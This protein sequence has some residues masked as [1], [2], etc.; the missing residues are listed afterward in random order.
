[1][2]VDNVFADPLTPAAMLER[3][4]P[5]VSLP[6]DRRLAYGYFDGRRSVLALVDLVTGDAKL[7]SSNDGIYHSAA[8]GRD[9]SAYFLLVDTVTREEIG[10]FRLRRDEQQPQ[11]LAKRKPEPSPTDGS[12]VYVTPRGDRVAILDCAAAQCWLRLYDANDGSPQGE[13]RTPHSTVLGVTDDFVVMPAGCFEGCPAA[14]FSIPSLAE[15]TFGAVCGRARFTFESRI[16]AITTGRGPDCGGANASDLT[17]HFVDGGRLDVP[18]PS[19]NGAELV[20]QTS[21]DT[22]ELPNGWILVA[23]NGQLEAPGPVTLVNAVSGD[24]IPMDFRP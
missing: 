12:T 8:L 13:L 7:V 10:L 16:G 23:P 15:E 17:S 6:L 5:F 1:M 11:L 9:G 21:N 14:A 2:D 24:T 3:A 19:L 20:E 22:S 18:D 4:L